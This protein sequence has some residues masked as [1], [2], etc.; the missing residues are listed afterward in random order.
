MAKLMPIMLALKQVSFGYKA[1]MPLSV[2][3]ISLNLAQGSCTAI[4][5][6]N[7]AG[8]ST[9]IS[10]MS[11]LL[12]A[13]TGQISYPF[14]S[15]YT[16]QEAIAQKVALVP[17]DFAFYHELSV[18][19]NLAFFVSISE[20][21]RSLHSNHIKSAIRACGL[22]DV[23]NK[24]AGSL[25]GGYKRRLNIAIALSK[26][27][28]IIFLDE[29]TVGI[30]PLSRDA[31]INLLLDLKQQGKTL[32]YTSHLLHEVELLCDEVVFLN[33]GK[34][35][36]NELLNNQK[37]SLNF[38]TVKPLSPTQIALFTQ[39]I[40]ILE[41]GGHQLKVNNSEQLA[42]AFTV[43]ANLSHDIKTLTFSNS[44][45]EQL[46]RDLFSESSC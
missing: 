31:I 25:S 45:I 37:P 30:D 38:T 5:G 42:S 15:L 46:Y 26:Q 27:P 21:N 7:G 20:K 17:Q 22:D 36:A 3:N 43:L 6:P 35:V 41:N 9:L 10:L 40:T 14:Y 24:M 34:V 18:H 44:H 12:T 28:D 39:P 2:N 33:N 11:G 4:L 23:I 8:K 1:N 29:P 13:Q 19:D 32:V 16:T